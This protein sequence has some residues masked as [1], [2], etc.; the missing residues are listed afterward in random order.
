MRCLFCPRAFMFQTLTLWDAGWHEVGWCDS[1]HRDFRQSAYSCGPFPSDAVRPLCGGLV[2]FAPSS[3]SA[4]LL[5]LAQQPRPGHLP[6]A[7]H[8]LR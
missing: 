8:R 3:G 6:V 5:H 7:H 1:F 4:S 2:V